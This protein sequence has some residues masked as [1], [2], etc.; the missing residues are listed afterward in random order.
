MY[1]N[2]QVVFNKKIIKCSIKG[3][4]DAQEELRAQF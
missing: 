3:Y 1:Y 4:E 2:M